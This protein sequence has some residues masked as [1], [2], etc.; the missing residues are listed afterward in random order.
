[1]IA[2]VTDLEVGEFI[3]SL[4]DTHIY[5]NHLDQVEE[6][7]SRKPYD[8]PT[9]EINNKET[10]FEYDYEDL[11]LGKGI[12]YVNAGFRWSISD[13]LLLELNFNDI[14][15]NQNISETAHREF[16][17]LYSQKF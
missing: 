1:M 12:G 10:L 3:H 11:S 17:I 5:I 9:I 6:Q 16:K 13:N 15:R 8:L 7:L 2:S 14:N 4:G